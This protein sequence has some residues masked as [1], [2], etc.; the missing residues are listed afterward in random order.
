M[1]PDIVVREWF[2]QVWT[3]QREEAVDRLMA[4]DALVHDLPTPD[5]AP[6]RGPEA[7][8]PF[9][10]KFVAAFPDICIDVTRTLVDGDMVAAHC[11][12]KVTH[13]GDGLG[14]MATGRTATIS[15]I[16]IAR[17]QNG[18]IVEGWNSF[19][20]LSLYQQLGLLPAMA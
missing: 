12:V 3:Q 4:P 16:C 5:G 17:V 18:Q 2:E 8:K 7:F 13:G 9:H 15:G 6:M 1:T 10:R 20:F 11:R 19:D 14:M